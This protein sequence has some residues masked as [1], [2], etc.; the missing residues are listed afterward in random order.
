MKNNLQKNYLQETKKIKKIAEMQLEAEI[1]T[2]EE[3]RKILFTLLDK[4][5]DYVN[6]L[7]EIK[8]PKFE[9]K[10]I[11]NIDLL[12]ITNILFCTG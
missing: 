5:E 12:G 2:D 4:T 8:I 6:N 7:G 10:N 1:I 3:Y 11:E 9:V